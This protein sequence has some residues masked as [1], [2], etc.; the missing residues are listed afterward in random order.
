MCFQSPTCIDLRPQAV[1]S[2]RQNMENDPDDG[3]DSDTNSLIL[4]NFDETHEI[5]LPTVIEK[6]HCEEKSEEAQFKE[7]AL[8][9]QW[10]EVVRS[11]V[12]G[13]TRWDESV[14]GQSRLLEEFKKKAL[15]SRDARERTTPTF[16][17]I[18]AKRRDS[19]EFGNL[20]GDTLLKII[21][22]LLE[23]Q[24]S[25]LVENG[26]H[27]P[28]DD[29]ILRV[30]MEFNNTDF[31]ESVTSCSSEIPGKLDELLNATD[32]DGMNCLHYAF[33]EQLPKALEAHQK[34]KQGST[35]LAERPILSITIK[36]IHN[37]V[38][39]AKAE[40]MVSRDNYGNTPIHYAMDFNNCRL[41]IKQYNNI[42]QYLVSTGDKLLKKAPDQQF[43]LNN[44]SPY[45]Y[46][47]RTQE[48]WHKQNERAGVSTGP[49]TTHLERSGNFTGEE[50]KGVIW[51]SENTM[52]E[53]QRDTQDEYSTE[54]YTSPP[55]KRPTRRRTQNI[56]Q[57]T[58]FSQP[59]TPSGVKLDDDKP[60]VVK[61]VPDSDIAASN[62]G[63]FVKV[64]YIRTRTDMEAKELLY[65]KIAS[66]KPTTC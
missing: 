26:L 36:T 3:T 13:E 53:L 20:P 57:T 37:F 61:S 25:A 64:H 15:T 39:V 48:Q 22:Y 38:Q 63:E 43:N 55:P 17:H 5:D 62:I 12:S 14:P 6:H 47:L 30:A 31:I 23:Y 35:I 49:A 9:Q 46:F 11:L 4:G 1:V 21:K 65:G 58:N 10:K 2:L 7:Q 52:D 41:Q 44:E 33:K 54:E 60:T 66:G 45:L 29:P 16:L 50:A 59:K 27:K 56:D 18:L 51:T 34:I 28:K 32:H 19:E 24:D 42:V 8:E 40:T